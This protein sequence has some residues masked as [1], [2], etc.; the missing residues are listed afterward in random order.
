M[1][2]ISGNHK[3]LTYAQVGHF[4]QPII[5]AI[6]LIDEV[7]HRGTGTIPARWARISKDLAEK[8]MP[9]RVAFLRE[10]YAQDMQKKTPEHT[11]GYGV[12]G[13]LIGTVENLMTASRKIEMNAKAF[14]EKGV[15]ISDILQVLAQRETAPM[16]APTE[17]INTAP[18]QVSEVQSG[19][20]P[21]A[22]IP[23]PAY[24]R[25]DVSGR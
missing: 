16:L 13:G 7:A 22:D 4:W 17:A 5:D 20:K 18:T 8:P 24:L 9:E 25:R 14:K 21:L 6:I 10:Y 11:K 1:S 12:H 23:I 3:D 2:I 19:G 15:D